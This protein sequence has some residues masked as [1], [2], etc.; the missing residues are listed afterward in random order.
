MPDPCGRRTLWHQPLAIAFSEIAVQFGEGVERGA[1][2]AE[3]LCMRPVRYQRNAMA[4][5]V[6]VEATVMLAKAMPAKNRF[7]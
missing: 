2:Q 7:R 1:L 3:S 4:A 6:A 5:M